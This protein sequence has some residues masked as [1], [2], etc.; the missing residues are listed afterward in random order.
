[1]KH[2]SKAIKD[3]IT[4]YNS[5]DEDIEY[6]VWINIVVYRT[7]LLKCFLFFVHEQNLR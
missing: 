5:N 4:D 3:A 6:V 7:V 2:L 1:M